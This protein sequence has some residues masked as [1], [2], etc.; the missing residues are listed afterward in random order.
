MGGLLKGLTVQARAVCPLRG[1]ALD[2]VD[3]R[4]CITMWQ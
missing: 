2:I 3:A 4:Q 1:V